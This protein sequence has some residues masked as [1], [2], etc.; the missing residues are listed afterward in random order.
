MPASSTSVVA[1]H[2]TVLW[3]G[4]EFR[5][6]DRAQWTDAVQRGQGIGWIHLDATHETA[7]AWLVAL[8]V[9]ELT[10]AR[11][12]AVLDDGSQAAGV[13]QNEGDVRRVS[14][15]AAVVRRDEHGPELTRQ[16]VAVLTSTRWVVTL[17]EALGDDRQ[18][19][20]AELLRATE[21]AGGGSVVSGPDLALRVVLAIAEGYASAARDLAAHISTDAEDAGRRGRLLQSFNDLE[22]DASRLRRRGHP[23]ASAWFAAGSAGSN[24]ATGIAGVLDETL[25]RVHG[26][27]LETERRADERAAADQRRR[28]DS[29]QLVLGLV[30]VV[31][32]G[33]SLVAG[34]LDALP[35]WQ[36]VGHRGSVF[37]GLSLV[38]G[39]V[40]WLLTYGLPAMALR[41]F[42]L[43]ERVAF[44]VGAVLIVGGGLIALPLTAGFDEEPPEISVSCPPTTVVKGQQAFVVVSA[45]D[46]D[47]RLV[48]DPSSVVQLPTTTPG[49]A[50]RVFRAV[51]SFGRAATASCEYRIV[52]K[53]PALRSLSTAA[54]RPASHVATDAPIQS[55]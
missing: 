31:L 24:T 25:V 33:P 36:P 29:W 37:I 19:L 21:A 15:A 43:G 48:L 42:G 23:A 20:A 22:S 51:D 5:S 26:L 2:R 28:T 11:L 34:V 49:A 46:A 6:V 3:D 55:K 16:R 44:A 32:L 39:G 14:M 47:S 54:R 4:A 30:A 18:G 13:V 35:G 45:S 9:P 53:P 52:D 38:S 27:R 41:R 8:G 1:P 17:G 50:H 40:L 7:I 12:Q 10:E